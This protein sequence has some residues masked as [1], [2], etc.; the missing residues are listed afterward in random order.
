MRALSCNV[1]CVCRPDSL[2]GAM[3]CE[4]KLSG[5]LI[6]QREVSTV[7]CQ[8]GRLICPCKCRTALLCHR[9]SHAEKYITS[10]MSLVCVVSAPDQEGG[11]G[12]F[13]RQLTD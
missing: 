5:K 13:A 3:C 6:S 2:I 10:I 11:H 9:A 7:L 8:T 12:N 4:V 1:V